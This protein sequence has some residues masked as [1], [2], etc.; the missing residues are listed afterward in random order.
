MWIDATDERSACSIVTSRVTGSRVPAAR[1]PTHARCDDVL[2]SE[3]TKCV[4]DVT[5]TDDFTPT[6]RAIVTIDDRGN[7][8][9]RTRAHAAIS[10]LI[11]I[12]RSQRSSVSGCQD[13]VSSHHNSGSTDRFLLPSKSNQCPLGDTNSSS[14]FLPARRFVQ[15][16]AMRRADAVGVVAHQAYGA[17]ASNEM[18][19]PRTRTSAPAGLEVVAAVAVGKAVIYGSRDHRLPHMSSSSPCRVD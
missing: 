8:H 19:R 9:E 6:C 13:G 3:A 1:G 14:N 15:R 4:G 16:G 17:D 11:R 5:V 10:R 12:L 18:A 2:R 7:G